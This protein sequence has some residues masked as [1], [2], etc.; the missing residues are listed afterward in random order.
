MA[1][2]YER[3]VISGGAFERGERHGAAAKDKIAISIRNYSRMF[4]AFSGMGWNEARKLS[5]TF[6]PDIEEYAA[7]VLLEMKGIA[8]GSGVD[9]EDILTLNARSEIALD[10]DGC[11]SLGITPWIAQDNKAYV[12]QNWDWIAP[13]RDALVL[14]EVTQPPAPSLL[15]LAEAGM[16]S[17]KGLNS[18][19][20]GV[21]HNA[22]STGK[23]GMGVPIFV[24][25]REV[26]NA[27][28]LGDA[29]EAVARAKRAS[30]A[31]FLVGT[32]DGEI[33]DIEFAPEDFD[34]LYADDGYIAHTNHFTSLRLVGVHDHGKVI[35]PDTFHRL[36]R[37]KR[38]IREHSGS[39]N[40][41]MMSTFLRDHTNAP[42]SICRHE[43]PRDPEGKRLSSVY[44]MI[45]DMAERTL[46]IAHS[47]PCESNYFPE[48]L[49]KR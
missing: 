7:E 4:E 6:L 32:A 40:I 27:P 2:K 11:T 30:S 38:L 48:S 8:A 24:I 20:L 1:K 45:I 47:N 31:N 41:K 22:L 21:C 37:I 10:A 44:S 14:L 5:E 34:V 3:I 46:W 42:D 18:A 33:I 26:L 17:G 43:D 15:I 16:V 29:V 49:S 25:L 28:T 12:A 9:F 13:Q 36:G 23:R 19:G 39:I 35:L